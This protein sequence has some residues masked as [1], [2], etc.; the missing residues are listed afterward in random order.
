MDR[1]AVFESMKY[2]RKTEQ[3]NLMRQIYKNFKIFVF[4]AQDPFWISFLPWHLTPLEQH[5][6]SVLSL[7]TEF[8][9]LS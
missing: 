1:S 2:P 8:A 7:S 3:V 9:R 6:G 4:W 5:L